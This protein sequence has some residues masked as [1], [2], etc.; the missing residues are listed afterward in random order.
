LKADPSA[1]LWLEAVGYIVPAIVIN[2]VLWVAGIRSSNLGP[3]STNPIPVII[4][5]IAVTGVEE[6][7]FRGALWYRTSGAGAPLW[8]ATALSAVVF[9]AF[10]AYAYGVAL[11]SIG[12]AAGAGTLFYMI[13]NATKDKYGLAVNTGL[14]LG[15]NLALLGV[16]LLAAV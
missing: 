3:T 9:A 11:I 15:Y 12:F 1:P 4:L 13:Y 10:H 14:H 6:L 2:L 16:F 5:Q 8:F 7:L